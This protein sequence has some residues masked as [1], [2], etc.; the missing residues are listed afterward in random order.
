MK[1]DRYADD[2]S[3]EVEEY[4]DQRIL[5]NAGKSSYNQVTGKE[6]EDEALTKTSTVS[7]S[8]QKKAKMGRIACCCVSLVIL[9]GVA[10]G[11][12]F[13]AMN[14]K[15]GKSSSP[16]TT[17]TTATSSSASK[18]HEDTFCQPELHDMREP[19]LELH[20][21]AGRFNRT[22]DN[23][24][25]NLLEHA[26]KEGYNVA[27]G[28]CLD[29]FERFMIG[30]TLKN[31]ALIE[32]VENVEESDENDSTVEVDATK[33]LV[34]E[35]ETVI[36][37]DGCTEDEAFASR[38]PST[39]GSPSGSRVLQT[40]SSEPLDAG[41]IMEEIVKRIKDVLPDLGEIT[42][43][44]I[45]AETDGGVATIKKRTSS[46]VSTMKGPAERSI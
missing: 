25:T 23:E 13:L 44:I 29:E 28:G 36:S 11:S 6:D 4:H 19:V 40:L 35:F 2:E 9:G 27:A 8:N 41:K 46:V 7:Q 30:S 21:N 38:Y 18:A 10:V 1:V 12:Y 45:H 16:T 17:M 20:I 43:A 24:E 32:N 14:V 15:D 39:Y 3:S 37:C 26:I 33:T 22:I 5:E 42:D 31:T 34:L